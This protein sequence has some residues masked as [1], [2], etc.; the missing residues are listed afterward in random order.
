V[1][2]GGGENKPMMPKKRNNVSEPDNRGSN[3]VR[4]R[5]ENPWD[6]GAYKEINR[7]VETQIGF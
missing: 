1:I 7:S 5:G 2:L 6:H 4:N 3:A